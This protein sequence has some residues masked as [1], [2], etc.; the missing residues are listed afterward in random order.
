MQALN[1]LNE[2][3]ANHQY[4]WVVYIFLG[5][6]IR[7]LLVQAL[8][9][10]STPLLLIAL[11]LFTQY[12]GRKGKQG[13]AS[14]ETQK[15]IAHLKSMLNEQRRDIGNK[16]AS[17]GRTLSNLNASASSRT[18]TNNKSRSRYDRLGL[19]GD[20]VKP[21]SESSYHDRV[22][23]AAERQC[24]FRSTE[25]K[26][27]RKRRN[28]RAPVETAG[29]AS[30]AGGGSK[31]TYECIEQVLD[32]VQLSKYAKDVRGLGA[33]DVSHLHDLDM[34]DLR[35]IGMRKLEIKRFMRKIGELPL[36]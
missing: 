14:L 5:V 22:R 27:P 36:S 2:R 26:G 19:G 10:L 25:H 35:E 18:R 7:T 21:I 12:N 4:R 13:A 30:A 31:K 17:N 1:Q 11:L 32:S 9:P 3:L 29:S 15:G 28:R 33:E 20:S 23:R 6:V 24:S 8:G 34:A 16:M